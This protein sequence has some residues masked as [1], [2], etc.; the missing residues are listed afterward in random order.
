MDADKIMIDFVTVPADLIGAFQLI[1]YNSTE[2]AVFK[3]LGVE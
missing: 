3:A 2:D 1:P